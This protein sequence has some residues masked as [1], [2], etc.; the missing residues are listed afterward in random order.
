M[1]SIT[2]SLL[3]YDWSGYKHQFAAFAAHLI[4]VIVQPLLA[5][6]L[7]LETL[8]IDEALAPPVSSVSDPSVPVSDPAL[9]R[10]VSDGEQGG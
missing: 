10:N 9:V 1:R 6:N 8:A 5:P 3:L 2:S 7:S 4:S